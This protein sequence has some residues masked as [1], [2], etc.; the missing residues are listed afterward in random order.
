MSSNA[1]TKVSGG[2][3]SLAHGVSQYDV[4]LSFVSGDTA[5]EEALINNFDDLLKKVI[6]VVGTT[7]GAA[8]TVDFSIKDKDDNEILANSSALA[9]GSTTP[10]SLEEPLFGQVKVGVTPSA[11]PLGALAVTVHLKGV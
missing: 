7:S 5:E 1:I 10:F 9:E 3:Q 4:V 11:D 2:R 6:V 8:V